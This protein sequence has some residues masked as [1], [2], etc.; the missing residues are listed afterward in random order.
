[1][2]VDESETDQ[3][4]LQRLQHPHP[5]GHDEDDQHV[6]STA[7]ALQPG[8]HSLDQTEH[9]RADARRDQALDQGPSDP[10][11]QVGSCGQGQ[12]HHEGAEEHHAGDGHQPA[13]EDRERNEKQA[14]QNEEDHRQPVEETL[15][16]R[17]GEGRADVDPLLAPQNVSAQDL[18]QACR[19]QVVAHVADDHHRE[20]PVGRDPFAAAQEE[21]PAPGP[22]PHRDEVDGHGGDEPEVVGRPQGGQHLP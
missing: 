22:E 14:N 7:Q 8:D 5:Q 6:A 11:Q 19:E 16:H 18:A 4:V 9:R 21:A 2:Q 13:Q 12:E 3:P 20:E 1:M 15:E 17:S 10:A